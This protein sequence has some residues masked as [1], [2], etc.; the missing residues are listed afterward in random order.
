LCPFGFQGHEGEGIAATIVDM[1]NRF[2]MI[3]NEVEVI[4]PRSIA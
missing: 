1:G 4:K 3:V 2:R